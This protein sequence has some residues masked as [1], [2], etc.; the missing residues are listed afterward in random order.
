MAAQQG[1]G[2]GYGLH[3]TTGWRP[4]WAAQCATFRP[5]DS[6]SDR[7]RSGRWESPPGGRVQ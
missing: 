2:G 6:D 3:R 1:F 4:V 7:A 5:F